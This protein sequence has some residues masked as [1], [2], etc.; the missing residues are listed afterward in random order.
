[1][2]T[3][4][5]LRALADLLICAGIMTIV[6]LLI[7]ALVWHKIRNGLDFEDLEYIEDPEEL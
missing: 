1:M 5:I 6:C 3:A 4:I 2:T 7:C